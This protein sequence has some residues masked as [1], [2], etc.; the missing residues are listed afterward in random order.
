MALITLSSANNNEHLLFIHTL[1]SA[2]KLHSC[3]QRTAAEDLVDRRVDGFERDEPVGGEAIRSERRAAV[4]GA[5]QRMRAVHMLVAGVPIQSVRSG[6]C[7]R[8][9]FPAERRREAAARAASEWAVAA[10]AGGAVARQ[11]LQL[12]RSLVPLET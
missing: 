6:G 4:S 10:A 3:R 2:I 11:Q 8:R 9:R 7:L 5:H 12:E 1:M